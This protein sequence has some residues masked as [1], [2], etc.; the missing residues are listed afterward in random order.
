MEILDEISV[1]HKDGYIG[2]RPLAGSFSADDAVVLDSFSEGEYS[3]R[4]VFAF[5]S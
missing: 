3:L 4:Q 2:M 5:G 1:W